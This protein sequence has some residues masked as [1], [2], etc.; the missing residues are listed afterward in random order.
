MK[1][2]P[3]TKWKPSIRLLPVLAYRT[4]SWFIRARPTVFSTL[5]M[6]ST[7][8]PGVACSHSSPTTATAKNPSATNRRLRANRSRRSNRSQLPLDLIVDGS[9][10][11]FRGYTNGILDGVGIR[12]SVSDEAHAFHAQQRSPAIF[13]VVETLLEIGERTAREQVADLAGDGGFQSFFQ[14]GPHQIGHAL[15]S[16]EHHVAHKSIG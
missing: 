7:L 2:F 14:G 5:S 1:A 6:K 9:L 4:K 12:R 11:E 10:R 16:L 8:K 15:G 3:Q 13:R